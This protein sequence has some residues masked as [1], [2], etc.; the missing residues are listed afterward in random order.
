MKFTLTTDHMGEP[1]TTLEEWGIRFVIKR[2]MQDADEDAVL[3]IPGEGATINVVPSNFVYLRISAEATRAKLDPRHQ[4]GFGCGGI[5]Y[6]GLKVRSPQ[7]VE[8]MLFHGEIRVPTPAVKD[9][10]S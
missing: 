9:L 7:G 2:R 4:G 10:L 5:Y 1:V 8:K 3:T 6:Y